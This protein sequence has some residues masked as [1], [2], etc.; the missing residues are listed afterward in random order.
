[1]PLTCQVWGNLLGSMLRRIC[2]YIR[3]TK[4]AVAANGNR[5]AAVACQKAGAIREN[6]APMQPYLTLPP[7]PWAKFLAVCRPCMA[8]RAPLHAGKARYL[9]R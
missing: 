5:A 9:Y 4:R 3:H 2:C 6:A 7:T 1:M 8:A